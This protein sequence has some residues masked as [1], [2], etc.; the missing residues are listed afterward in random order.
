M[1][2]LSFVPTFQGRKLSFAKTD[3]L[4]SYEEAGEEEE[5]RSEGGFTQKHDSF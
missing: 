4:F 1:R 2:K 5:S 3:V